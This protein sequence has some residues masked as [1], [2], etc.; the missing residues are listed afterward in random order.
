MLAAAALFSCVQTNVTRAPLEEGDGSHRAPVSAAPAPSA[1]VPAITTPS[2]SPT[3][4]PAPAPVPSPS[5]AVAP[6]PPAAPSPPSDLRARAAGEP[7]RLQAAPCRAEGRHIRVAIERPESLDISYRGAAN[8]IEVRRTIAS[9]TGGFR[10]AK[11][12]N[13]IFEADLWVRG[14]GISVG[15]LGTESCKGGEPADAT[16]EVIAHYR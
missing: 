7:L 13:G 12:S 9:G 6:T 10:H 16:F 5:A 14:S 15:A 8:G 4:P 2:P 11:L 1:T 3:S